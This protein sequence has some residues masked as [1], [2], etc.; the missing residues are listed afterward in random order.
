MVTDVPKLSIYEES[1]RGISLIAAASSCIQAPFT[2][3]A[4]S[5]PRR[6]KDTYTELSLVILEMSEEVYHLYGTRE[7]DVDDGFIRH[8]GHQLN[9]PC[10]LRQ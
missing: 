3:H 9:V 7:T 4:S 2:C 1:G 6:D 10:T 8:V 5:E